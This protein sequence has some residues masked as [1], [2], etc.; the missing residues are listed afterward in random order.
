M[1]QIKFT[2]AMVLLLCLLSS[3][4]VLADRGRTGHYGG[5]GHIDFGLYFGLPYMPYYPS[6]YSPYPYYPYPY[7]PYY[8]YPPIVVAPQAPSVY[9]EQ[10][11]QQATPQQAAPQQENYWYYCDKSEGYYPYI[12]ECPEGWRK[13]LPEPPKH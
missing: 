7:Y 10:G 2:S 5:R 8:P 6:L 9:I 13:V 1:K 4:T 3:G 12:K 11:S